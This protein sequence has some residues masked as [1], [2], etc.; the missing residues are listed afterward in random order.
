MSNIDFAIIYEILQ[1]SIWRI[2]HILEQKY[3]KSVWFL[4]LERYVSIIKDYFY[5]S[6]NS[7]MFAGLLR[8]T[9]MHGDKNRY[10]H[11]KT[12]CTIVVVSYAQYNT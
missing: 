8:E 4:S 3:Q 6:S 12:I 5:D 1:L 9:L 2:T 10:W 7:K 11:Y